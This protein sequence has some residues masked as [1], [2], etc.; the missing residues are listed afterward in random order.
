MSCHGFFLVGHK[1]FGNL[2]I[3]DCTIAIN[4]HGSSYLLLSGGLG[5]LGS[6]VAWL[7]WAVS[8]ISCPVI[9][10]SLPPVE[11]VELSILR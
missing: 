5:W 2:L 4:T 6:A 8:R 9:H 7:L 10:F 11:P 1:E 3:R